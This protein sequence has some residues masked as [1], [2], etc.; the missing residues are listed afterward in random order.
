MCGME[1]I[2][3]DAKLYANGNICIDLA[4]FKQNL[5]FNEFKLK[6]ITHW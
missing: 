3:W 2:F 4:E 6:N 1:I 5:I